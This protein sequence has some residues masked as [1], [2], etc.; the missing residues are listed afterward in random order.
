MFLDFNNGPS[1][2]HAVR[3]LVSSSYDFQQ[4]RNN[5]N[6]QQKMNNATSMIAQEP[7]GPEYDQDHGN[8]VK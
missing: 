8:N 2:S 1:A 7:N 3:D 4:D 6:H 5:C